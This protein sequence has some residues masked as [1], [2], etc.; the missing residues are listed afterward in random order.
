MSKRKKKYLRI[1]TQCSQ[2]LCRPSFSRLQS[3]R[4]STPCQLCTNPHPA[5]DLSG[6]SAS[7]CFMVPDSMN[8]FGKCL[9]SRKLVKMVKPVQT[10]WTIGLVWQVVGNRQP[11][12]WNPEKQKPFD[13][14]ST[15]ILV[16]K[17][18]IP[19]TLLHLWKW[20]NN[21]TKNDLKQKKEI[22]WQ[23]SLSFFYSI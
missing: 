20:D 19:S 11:L 2:G 10:S 4:H 12:H 9:V 5:N 13:C 15:A 18:C 3:Q 23:Y 6:P 16:S 22:T 21:I 17:Y 1:F 14:T 8:K 7:P